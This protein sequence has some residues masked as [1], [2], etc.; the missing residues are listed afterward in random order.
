MDLLRVILLF[1]GLV[2]YM[3]PGWILFLICCALWCYTG[4]LL[5]R[6]THQSHWCKQPWES[7]CCCR[8]CRHLEKRQGERNEREEKESQLVTLHNTVTPRK[9]LYANTVEI[10][11][12]V[13]QITCTGMWDVIPQ[14]LHSNRQLLLLQLQR[15]TSGPLRCNPLPP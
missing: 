12:L 2:K 13:F 5:Y 4:N 7:L 1:G 11:G 10:K 14:P 6:V 9:H 3:H 8:V 15:R